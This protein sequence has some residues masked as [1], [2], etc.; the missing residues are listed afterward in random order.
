MNIDKSLQLWN[1]VNLVTNEGYDTQAGRASLSSTSINDCTFIVPI[2]AEDQH[3]VL[4]A[5][6]FYHHV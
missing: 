2:H 6:Y 5:N 3:T 1:Q 4:F